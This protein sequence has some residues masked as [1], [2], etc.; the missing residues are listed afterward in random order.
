M[1]TATEYSHMTASEFSKEEVVAME[2][3]IARAINF[4]FDTCTASE[5]IHMS[6]VP[7]MMR[8]S[9]AVFDKRVDFMGLY[10]SDLS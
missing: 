7:M 10:L 3:E 6:I 1:M 9:T 8:D 5:A 4:E 2:K